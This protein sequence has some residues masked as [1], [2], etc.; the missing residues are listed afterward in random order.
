MLGNEN[1]MNHESKF[2]IAITIVSSG[3]RIDENL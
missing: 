3:I 1:S 2:W